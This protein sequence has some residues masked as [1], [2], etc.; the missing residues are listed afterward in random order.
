MGAKPIL[1][2]AAAAFATSAVPPPPAGDAAVP[3]V[4]PRRIVS[5]NLCADQMVLDLADRAQIAGLSRNADDPSLSAAA[6][7]ARG[8]NI[9][10]DS[11]EALLVADPD[12]I[13]AIPKKRSGAL[14]MLG[15]QDFSVVDAPSAETYPAIVD[16]L[17]HVGSA[18]GHPARAEALIRAMDARLAALPRAPGR[19]RVAAY[20]QRR[21]FMTG[22]GTLIDDLMGR[23]GL[24]NLA[25]RLGKPPLSQI[26]LEEMVAAKPDLL[27]LES[28][29]ADITDQGT[30]MLHHPALRDIPK[31]WIPQAWTVCGSPEYVL[32]AESL[33]RQIAR[34]DH[35]NSTPGWALTP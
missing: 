16:Q 6:G 24:V 34:L 17:R 15:A 7:R 8:L 4:A 1:L 13:V 23:L 14:G 32:A 10:R 33:T 28:A 31:L 25:A 20:Y 5:V 35:Q 22:T 18:V 3:G 21:G 26:T 12:M 19:G 11:A 2:A 9:M 27:I 30:E 29:T